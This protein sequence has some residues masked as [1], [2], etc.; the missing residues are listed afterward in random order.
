M[1]AFVVLTALGAA[2]STSALASAEEPVR[3]VRILPTVTPAGDGASKEPLH[4]PVEAASKAL[5]VRAQELD[6]T[7][8]SAV[9]DLGL[10]LEVAGS[11]QD[12]NAMRDIDLLLRAKAQKGLSEGA[13]VVSPRIEEE[14]PGSNAFMIRI[15]A[16][17]PG[18]KELRVR[19][20][21]CRGEDVSA[22]GLVLLRDILK[23]TSFATAVAKTSEQDK[24][25]EPT[26]ELTTHSPGREILATQSAIFGGFAAFAVQRASNS[27][28][29]R[30][31]LPLL[32]IGS[33]VGIGA[34]LLASSE[35]N[36]STGNAWYITA[37]TFWGSFSGIA[38]ANGVSVNKFTD[39]YAYGVIGGFAGLGLAT[40]ALVKNKMDEGD[41]LLA[42]SGGALGSVAGGAIQL[43]SA[44]TVKPEAP[45]QVGA[46][47]GAAIGTVALGALATRVKVAPSKVLL[48][49]L[50][51]GLGGLGGAAI[52]SPLVFENVTKPRARLFL[53]SAL[54][55]A[56]IGGVVTWFLTR[57]E[58]RDSPPSKAL[59]IMP[60]FGVIES[61]QRDARAALEQDPAISAS[62]PN[63]GAGFSGVF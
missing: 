39:R 48:V 20:S 27:D 25:E 10:S 32:A 6:L 43:V 8:R 56:A 23:S 58:V 28:D 57:K 35:W 26:I 1:R 31:L 50:G 63:Y 45:P 54:S 41:A 17:A 55:G 40:V 46:A 18:G 37:G 62:K 19:V 4:R 42:H 60:T 7:L 3:V 9:Q 44:G 29:P 21:R 13:F 38:L 2:L 15:V 36:I 51:I 16:A 52:A 49:D 22:E 34:S 24:L 11:A 12:A 30:V 61:P 33:G 53:L 14:S 5:F 59:R 47:L